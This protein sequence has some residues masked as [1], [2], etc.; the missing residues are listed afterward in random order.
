MILSLT[1][2]FPPSLPITFIVRIYTFA[3]PNTIPLL[4]AKAEILIICQI[5]PSCYSPA[6]QSKGRISFTTFCS[7]QFSWTKR[8]SIIKLLFY[9]FNISE[10]WEPCFPPL[11]LL[12]AQNPVVQ[13][14]Q[15]LHCPQP[16]LS[17]P[18][19]SLSFLCT[20]GLQNGL[21]IL[22]GVVWQH[23]GTSAFLFLFMLYNVYKIL[24][25]MQFINTHTE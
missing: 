17:T 7:K 4:D 8:V 14:S 6:V 11:S 5:V 22:K 18:T 9:L 13:I 1:P 21:N 15:R 23:T 25:C 12:C 20:H 16:G 2:V 3:F 19:R 24:V 10:T